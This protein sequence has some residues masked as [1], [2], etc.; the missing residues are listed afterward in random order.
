MQGMSDE[1]K[2]KQGREKQ[3]GSGGRGRTLSQGDKGK[4][5]LGGAIEKALNEV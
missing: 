3:K 5:R 1:G 2:M 4:P